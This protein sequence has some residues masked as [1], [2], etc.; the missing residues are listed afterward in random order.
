MAPLAL[1]TTTVP[2]LRV[3]IPTKPDT[4]LGTEETMLQLV[5]FQFSIPTVPAAQMSLA[6]MA[7]IALRL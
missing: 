3:D 1:T 2:S 6:E 4:P 5:P 7:E